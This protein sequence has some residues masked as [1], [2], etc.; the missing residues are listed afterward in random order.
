MSS[1]IGNLSIHYSIQLLH[2]IHGLTV[3]DILVLR[4]IDLFNYSCVFVK[5]IGI[6]RETLLFDESN[7]IYF[8][9][10]NR[11]IRF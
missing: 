4:M 2:S 7:N 6:Y 10:R 3:N 11:V 5:L 9:V 1:S 8:G